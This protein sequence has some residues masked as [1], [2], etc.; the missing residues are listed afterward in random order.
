MKGRFLQA[1]LAAGLGLHMLAGSALA[2]VVKV[3]VADYSI[4]TASYFAEAEK[5]F[6]KGAE[7]RGLLGLKGHRSVGG[8]RISNYNAVPVA[9]AEKLVQYLLDYAKKPDGANGSV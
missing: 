7:S 6:L 4:R 3:V 8:I 9:G 5:A 2:G 1:V